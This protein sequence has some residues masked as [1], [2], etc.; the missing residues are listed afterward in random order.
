MP[1][2]SSRCADPAHASAVL[3]YFAQPIHGIALAHHPPVATTP[4]DHL[5]GPMPDLNAHDEL[6]PVAGTKETSVQVLSMRMRIH[7]LN[8]EKPAVVAYFK[9]IPA[10]K[11]EIALVHA[12]EVGIAELAMR[13]ERFKH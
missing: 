9:S 2:S 3:P 7:D 13:R 6:E 4:S 1:V 10:D 12:L 8:I 5:G 11:Q